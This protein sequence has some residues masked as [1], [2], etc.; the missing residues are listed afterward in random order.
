MKAFIS[1]RIPEKWLN[2]VAE[3]FEIDHH[4]WETAGAMLEREEVLAR[5]KDCNLLV[6]ESD[7]IDAEMLDSSPDLFVIVDFR[8]T[9][10]NVDIE[11]ATRN[12]IV[13]I[14]TPGRNADAVADLTVAYMIM[15]ARNVLQAIQ[16]LKSGKWAKYGKRHAYEIHQGYDM[17]GKVVGLLG[18]GYIGRLVAKRLA[19]FGVKLI[20]YD[21]YISAEIAES[22]GVELVEFDAVFK[23]SD[24]VSLHLPMNDSTRNMI[25]ERELKLMKSSAYLINTS[26]SGVM[27]EEVL[28]RCLHEKWI[29]GAA[30][31]VYHEEPVGADYPLLNI[32]NVICTPHICGASHDVVKHMAEI[33]ITG[34]FDFLNGEETLTIINPEAIG[35]AREKMAQKLGRDAG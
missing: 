15:V 20:G 17:P 18:L 28:I 6:T 13:I 4:D 25:G 23:E 34:L 32:P 12:G 35:K 2:K 11:A 22:V 21:P 24:F 27:E 14:N 31:D 9:V 30:I 1:S 29:A 16:T 3:K 26:R 19:G 33:G 7:M 5:M 8:G 10:V